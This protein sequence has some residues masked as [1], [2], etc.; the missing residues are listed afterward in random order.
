MDRC[1]R[2][3][4]YHKKG[5]NCCQAVLAAFSDIT[6]LSEAE[7]LAI[8]GGFGGGAGTGEL[9]GAITG[10][11]MA[12]S[13]MFPA[14]IEDPAAGKKRAVGLSRE[15]QKRFSEKF[16]HLRCA[17]LLAE[18]YQPDD[19]TPAAQRMELTN[20]CAIMIVT[21]VEIVEEMLNDR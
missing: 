11:V 13:Q 3:N 9:C 15:F 16:G 7:S 8:G 20:H 12:L 10:A 19:A 4:D 21:A 5:C 18:K 6:G 17:N 1:E 2:A 14:T